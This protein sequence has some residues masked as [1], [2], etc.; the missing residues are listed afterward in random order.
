M[1]KIIDGEQTWV[2]ERERRTGE[3]SE[4]SKREKKKVGWAK[5]KYL[6]D[7]VRKQKRKIMRE[8]IRE[9][10]WLIVCRQPFQCQWKDYIH[11]LL[12]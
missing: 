10:N 12:H 3:R 9:M 2:C 1:L 11:P 6:G 8:R 7:E 5:C 4:V